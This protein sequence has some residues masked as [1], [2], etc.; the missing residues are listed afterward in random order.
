MT[1]DYLNLVFDEFVELHGDKFF[2]DDRAIRTGLA[3]L[4]HYKVMV[5]GHQ[6]GKTLKERNA[7]Y[8]G[9]AHPEGYRKAM[10]KM[11]LAAKYQPAGHLLHR[12]ARRLSGHRRRGARPG[13]GD[14]REH[15]RDVAAADADHLRGDRR[16]AARAARWASASATAW[17]CSSTPTTRSSAPKAAPASSGRATPTLNE[18]AARALKIT[19]QAPARAG[20]HRRRDRRAA[21]RRIA[22][23]TKW[24]PG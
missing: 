11:Q 23:I 1:T 22:T 24:P 14:R 6:K 8:F 13:P 10:A 12:H 20:R 9:C 21:R 7:C 18:Q 17:P 16:R 15:V 3:K 4:D 2:G 5:V 19:S